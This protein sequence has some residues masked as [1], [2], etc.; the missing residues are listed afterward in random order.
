M[1]SYQNYDDVHA[2]SLERFEVGIQTI[3]S[4]IVYSEVFLH[5]HIVYINVL[6][7]LANIT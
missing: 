5:L 4:F 2:I 1:P 3:E 7:I 6:S